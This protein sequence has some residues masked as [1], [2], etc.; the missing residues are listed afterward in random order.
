MS[1]RFEA[2]QDFFDSATE[3]NTLIKLSESADG[4]EALF[5]KLS[6]VCIVTK[7]QVYVESVLEEY[8]YLLKNSE[9][10]SRN[11]STHMKM[12]SLRI[13][14]SENNALTGLQSHKNF[15]DEK[16]D[17]ILNYLDSIKYFYVD[18]IKIDNSFKFNTKFPLGKTGKDELCKLLWQIDG[19]INPFNNIDINKLDSL[20][21][22]RH[23]VVHRDRFNRTFTDVEN[24]FDFCKSL[25]KYIDDYLDKRL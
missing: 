24:D 12:N 19:N 21:L 11:I 2:T 7:F 10:K 5:L 15:T 16:R 20:L 18:D 17:S 4:N 22:A 13:S 23:L 9:T 25:V 1:Y 8:L 14:I 6:L 3:I